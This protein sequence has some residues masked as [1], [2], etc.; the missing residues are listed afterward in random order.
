[1]KNGYYEKGCCWVILFSL[2]LCMLFERLSSLV[3]RG[4]TVL[5]NYLSFQSVV[6]Y[7]LHPT[8]LYCCCVI[9]RDILQPI[10]QYTVYILIIYGC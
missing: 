4:I 9:S 5:G 3:G 2:G 1:M 10:H 7:V 8:G 6:V